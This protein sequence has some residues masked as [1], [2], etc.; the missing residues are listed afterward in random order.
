MKGPSV[1]KVMS[2]LNDKVS[3]IKAELGPR[4]TTVILPLFYAKEMVDIVYPNKNP[5]VMAAEAAAALAIGVTPLLVSMYPEKA[6]A[7]LNGV[8]DAFKS[9]YDSLKNYISLKD[10]I[11]SSES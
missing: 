11:A 4:G 3:N 5:Y 6:K 10:K 7:T 2:Y 1:R 9:G 8:K